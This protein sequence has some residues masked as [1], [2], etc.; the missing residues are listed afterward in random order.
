[1]TWSLYTASHH[2]CLT[3]QKRKRSEVSCDYRPSTFLLR[4]KAELGIQCDASKK[5]LGAA[6]IQRGKPIAYA[7]RPLTETTQ[8]YTQID[9]EMLVIIFSLEKFNQY[10]Y[11]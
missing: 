6:L 9:K 4:L 7:S 10:T 2:K 5:S 3:G 11:E 8:Q 1:M